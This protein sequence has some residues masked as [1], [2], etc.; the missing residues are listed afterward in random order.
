MHLGRG[1]AP[2]EVLFVYR[3]TPDRNKVAAGYCPAE[4]QLVRCISERISRS[5]SDC[6]IVTQAGM[7]VSFSHARLNLVFEII[8]HI[9]QCFSLNK[10]TP[11]SDAAGQAVVHE[12]VGTSSQP[13]PPVKQAASAYLGCLFLPPVVN[14]FPG[15]GHAG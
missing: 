4:A 9:E 13:L 14:R 8:M 3:D 7:A 10:Q 15:V 12:T 6:P 2:F 5:C 1:Y 11:V